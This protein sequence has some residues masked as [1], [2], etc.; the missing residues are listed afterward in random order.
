M[1]IAGGGLNL[2]M[3]EQL[4]DHR[5]TFSQGE[6]PAGIGMSKIVDAHIGKPRICGRCEIRH[7]TFYADMS[8]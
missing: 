5:Q 8:A 2:S 7:S 1:G 3:A 6:G 4:A